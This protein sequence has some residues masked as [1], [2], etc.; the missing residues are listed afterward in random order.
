MVK[1]KGISS[2]LNKSSGG[3]NHSLPN[4]AVAFSVK[5]GNRTYSYYENKSGM[6]M[7]GDV[8]GATIG[9]PVDSFQG[10]TPSIGEMYQRAVS[11]GGEVKLYSRK[12]SEAINTQYREQRQANYQEIAHAEMRPT[13][14]SH[15]RLLSRK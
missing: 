9:K 12:E 5:L 14:Y 2:R 4:G 13:G 15:R 7:R 10:K 1:S 8:P 6:L 11:G 3:G